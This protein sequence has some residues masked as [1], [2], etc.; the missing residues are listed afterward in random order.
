LCPIDAAWADT[1]WNGLTLRHPAAWE[2]TRLERDQI[3]WSDGMRAALEVRWARLRGRYSA[4]RVFKR[5]VRRAR[6]KGLPR[7]EPWSVPQS[8]QGALSRFRV[9]G[10]RWRLA[11][12]EGRGLLVY[13]PHCRR[14]SLIQLHP[15]LAGQPQLL[16]PLLASYEDHPHGA[17][18]PLSL[19]GIRARLP[20]GAR[21]VQFRFEAGRYRLLWRQGSLRIGLHRWA[22]AGVVLERQT[23]TAFTA[24]QFQMDPEGLHATHQNGFPAVEGKASSGY[25][26]PAI[27]RSVLSQRRVRVWHVPDHNSLLG[28]AVGGPGGERANLFNRLCDAYETG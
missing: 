17:E 23:L 10:F 14:Q 6:R 2:V 13:C 3:Q 5:F 28:V 11:G 22:P 26:L 20:G 8:W 12:A 19:F 15:C 1:A 27:F 4:E 21:L 24:R 18:I 7:L 9:S 25:R 16:P